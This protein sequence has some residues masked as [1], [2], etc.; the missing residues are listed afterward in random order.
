MPPREPSPK[1]EPEP[2]PEYEPADEAAAPS[3]DAET[4]L[5]CRS[6]AHVDAHAAQFPRETVQSLEHL[7]H[8]LTAPF[9]SRTD[10]ARAVFTWLHHNITYD[11]VAFFSNAI[12]P[13]TPESTLR[14][15]LAVCEGYA[16]L[17]ARLAQHAGLDAMVIHGHGK[18]FGYVALEDGAALP[19][20]DMNHAWNAVVMDDDEWHLVDSCWGAGALVGDGFQKVFTPRWFIGTNAEFGAR[21][22]PTEAVHQMREDGMVQSWEEYILAAAG[23][24]EFGHF[25]MHGY[26]SE[27][28]W[29]NTKCIAGGYR[30]TFHIEKLCWHMERRDWWEDCV[31]MVVAS[32]GGAG[33]G[34][35]ETREIMEREADGGWTVVMDVPPGEGIVTLFMITTMNGRDGKG[36]DPAEVK[37][38]L[39]R[40][41][42]GFQGVARWEVR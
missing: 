25:D 17:F 37:R 36:L 41:A 2:E 13:S 22:F 39:G 8:T 32:P 21:H 20:F 23:P 15:G 19:P 6:F 4:C 11:T 7:A 9:A 28:L 16:G 26:A 14:S 5:K 35:E 10:R 18:G 40:S 12:Q 31:L 29:P 38:L 24:V 30:H 3:T 34:K 27:T 33:T 1:P 42:M